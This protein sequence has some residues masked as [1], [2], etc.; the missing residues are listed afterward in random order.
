MNALLA[1]T[2]E[3]G[4]LRSDGAADQRQVLLRGSVRALVGGL[5]AFAVRRLP[6][7]KT[8][9]QKLPGDQELIRVVGAACEN[10]ASK[11]KAAT[12]LLADDLWPEAYYNAALRL[13]LTSSTVR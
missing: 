13:T 8:K 4:L 12:L 7:G 9:F 5:P 6:T 3:C 11:L 1:H 2:A 10:A